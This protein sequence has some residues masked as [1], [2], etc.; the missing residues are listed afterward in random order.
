MINFKLSRQIFEAR[1]YNKMKEVRDWI[2]LR[3]EDR[4]HNAKISLYIDLDLD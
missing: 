4:C 3:S 1:L 2:V